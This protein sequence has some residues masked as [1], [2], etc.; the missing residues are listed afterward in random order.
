MFVSGRISFDFDGQARGLSPASL[1]RRPSLTAPGQVGVELPMD[2]EEAA[3]E[4]SK[5]GGKTLLYVLGRGSASA[6][7]RWGALGSGRA[8]SLSIV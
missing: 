2:S 5:S 1:G 7:P 4:N 6:R 8:V 3:E